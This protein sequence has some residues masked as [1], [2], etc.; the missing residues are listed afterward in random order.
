MMFTATLDSSGL[1]LFSFLAIF[2]RCL[3]HE[4]FVRIGQWFVKPL[5]TKEADEDV[6]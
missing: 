4:N 2:F 1:V 5:Q 6:R 3:L